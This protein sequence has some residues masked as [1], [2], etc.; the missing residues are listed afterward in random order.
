MVTYCGQSSMTCYVWLNFFYFINIVPV[1]QA[2]LIWIK[3]NSRSVIY[4]VLIFEQMFYLLLSV[5]SVSVLLISRPVNYNNGTMNQQGIP[6]FSGNE[7]VITIYTYMF[8]CLCIMM[9]SSFSTVHYLHRHMKSMA[10]AGSHFTTPTMQSQMR[11]TITGILQ[12]VL[13]ILYYA[14]N[15]TDVMTYMLC[16]HFSFSSWVSFTV[17]SLYISGTTVN[18]SIG[19]MMFRQKAAN[20]WKALK[21]SVGMVTHD[22]KQQTR[23]AR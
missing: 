8:I 2:L 14:F 15:I 22:V 12:A 5:Y 1:H 4:A 18:L 17:T 7:I 19:Q 6:E 20:V 10:Q 3:R 9:A 23:G 13:Y 21:A 16:P 11:V